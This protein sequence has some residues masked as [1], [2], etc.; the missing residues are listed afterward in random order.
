VQTQRSPAIRPGNGKEPA[1]AK[2]S[3]PADT[4]PLVR[5]HRVLGR[6]VC[7]WGCTRSSPGELHDDEHRGEHDAG[8]PQQ[9]REERHADDA[10][11]LASIGTRS[12]GRRRALSRPGTRS[13]YERPAAWRQAW[14]RGPALPKADVRRPTEPRVERGSLRHQV[15]SS[16]AGTKRRSKQWPVD[17][18]GLGLLVHD[19][20]ERFAVGASSG[21][22]GEQ[23]HLARLK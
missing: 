15:S 1:S 20:R 23:D 9:S 14:G 12:R 16:Q 8:E 19:I 17:C 22:V 7:K 18:V 21:A 11:G 4:G 13:G 2:R 5:S 10:T 3:R 6:A